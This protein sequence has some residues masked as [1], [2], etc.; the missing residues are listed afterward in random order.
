[1]P[2]IVIE[3]PTPRPDGNANASVRR[4]RHSR[5]LPFPL[6]RNPALPRLGI[7][8]SEYGAAVAPKDTGV[9]KPKAPKACSIA[10]VETSGN[11][12][13]RG[14]TAPWPG[15]V[16]QPPAVNPLYTPATIR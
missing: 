10:M 11:T 6:C 16:R 9:T 13:P 8:L 7:S 3:T 4:L 14:E 5:T 15:P 12:I 2:C 1:M